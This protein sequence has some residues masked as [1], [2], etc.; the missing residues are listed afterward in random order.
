MVLPSYPSRCTWRVFNRRSV[1]HAVRCSTSIPTEPS[2]ICPHRDGSQISTSILSV[3]NP[4]V[5]RTGRHEGVIQQFTHHLFQSVGQQSER[6][7]TGSSIEKKKVLHEFQTVIYGHSILGSNDRSLSRCGGL[8]TAVFLA[9]TI[10]RLQHAA[11]Q[12]RSP[13][14]DSITYSRSDPLGYCEEPIYVGLTDTRVS[15]PTNRL[16]LRRKNAPREPLY[17]TLRHG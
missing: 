7:M 5:V 6:L 10:H 16:F 14:V 13:W 2:A 1:R 11:R 9:Q 8:A 3:T 4:S 17:D 12:F 15:S